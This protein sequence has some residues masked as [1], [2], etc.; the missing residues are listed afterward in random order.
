MNEYIEKNK[1]KQEMVDEKKKQ[2]RYQFTSE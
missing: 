1:L 2:L